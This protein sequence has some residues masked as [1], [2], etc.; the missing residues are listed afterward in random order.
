M[1]H[2]WSF[3]NITF[4]LR[5]HG[6]YIIILIFRNSNYAH[7]YMFSPLKN[8]HLIRA[9]A[10]RTFSQIH[11][12]T[13]Q[14]LRNIEALA[15]LHTHTNIITYGLNINCTVARIWGLAER[16]SVETL[17]VLRLLRMSRDP[18]RV[19][20]YCDGL[21]KGTRFPWLESFLQKIPFFFCVLA[22]KFSQVLTLGDQSCLQRLHRVLD[23]LHLM[24]K[25]YNML[26]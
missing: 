5:D 20:M 26:Y 14:G 7:S 10:V 13:W 24:D 23:H 19:R 3:S 1:S 11:P 18:V 4:I 22:V 8:V 16:I 15:A 2:Y 25:K 17:K 9:N 6:S 21:E 12:H